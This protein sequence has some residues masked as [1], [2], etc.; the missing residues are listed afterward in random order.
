MTP[1]MYK[2]WEL[3]TP[4]HLSGRQNGRFLFP[5]RHIYQCF[6]TT[7]PAPSNVFLIHWRFNNVCNTWAKITFQTDPHMTPAKELDLSLWDKKFWLEI[8]NLIRG[9]SDTFLINQIN[10]VLMALAAMISQMTRTHWKKLEGNITN[11]MCVFVKRNLS[12]FFFFFLSNCWVSE[13]YQHKKENLLQ[14]SCQIFH[15]ILVLN[16]VFAWGFNFPRVVKCQMIFNIEI[17]HISLLKLWIYYKTY[18]LWYKHTIRS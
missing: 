3:I 11:Q 9:L 8:I 14:H 5:G 1:F 12:F 16:W 18:D 10:I 15:R 6:S 13:L 2:K 4:C 7:D 17:S